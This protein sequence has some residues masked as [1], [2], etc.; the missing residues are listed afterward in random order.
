[1]DHWDRLLPGKI[2]EVH[3]EDLVDNMEAGTR[4][5]LDYCDLPFDHACLAFHETERTVNTASL[6]QVR[7]PLY[8]SSVS[9]WKNYEKHLQ[10]LFTALQQDF[11]E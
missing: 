1:M 9:R 2:F 10:P 8:S 6:A 3:Y 11:P 5:V 7:Q 4:R